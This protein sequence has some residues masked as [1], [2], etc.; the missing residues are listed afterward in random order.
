MYMYFAV[1]HPP[2]KTPQGNLQFVEVEEDK[3]QISNPEVVS[4]IASLLSTTSDAVEKALCFRVVGNKLGSV[5][6]MHTVD[7]AV[8]GRDAFAK[9]IYERLFTW[10]VGRINAQLEVKVVTPGDNSVIGVLDIYGFEIFDNNRYDILCMY[11]A[12]L[13]R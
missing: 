1:T 4:N 8:Y 6:K 5:E 3:L 10:I 11:I 13:L 7:Q 12:I 2:P 9:A